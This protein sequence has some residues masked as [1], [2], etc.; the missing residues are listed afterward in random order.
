MDLQFLKS[1]TTLNKQMVHS[2]AVVADRTTPSD[3]QNSVIVFTL[4]SY[5]VHRSRLVALCQVTVSFVQVQFLSFLSSHLSMEYTIK[6]FVTLHG[7]SHERAIHSAPISSVFKLATSLVSA[8]DKIGRYKCT[9]CQNETY[10]T[11]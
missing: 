1:D 7:G 4:N 8:E 3:S 6:T 9:G 10:R 2:P 11:E 5:C